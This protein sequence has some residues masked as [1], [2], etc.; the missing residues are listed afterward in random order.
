MDI[1]K[2]LTITTCKRL[3]M[4]YYILWDRFKGFMEESDESDVSLDNKF[5]PKSKDSR[6]ISSTQ[7]II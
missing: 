2:Q 1:V 3:T 4:M 7:C 5:T 6:E